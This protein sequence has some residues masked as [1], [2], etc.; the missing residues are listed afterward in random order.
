MENFYIGNN[1]YIDEN[2]DHAIVKYT[3]A[4]AHLGKFAKVYAH[5]AACYL[6]L[7]DYMNALEDCNKA[8]AL[9]ASEERCYLRKGSA[10]FFLEDYESAKETFEAGKKICE[11]MKTGKR[12]TGFVAEYTRFIR[13]CDSE[14]AEEAKEA[15]VIQAQKNKEKEIAAA[16]AAEKSKS[17]KNVALPLGGVKYQYYQSNAKLTIDVLIKGMKEEDVAVDITEDSIKVVLTAA[18]TTN[19]ETVI[20]KPLYDTVVVDKCKVTVKKTKVE[21][22]LVKEQ[23]R[24]W[25]SLEGAAKEKKPSTVVTKPKETTTNKD[26][27]PLPRAYA[28][29]KDWDRVEQA[30]TEELDAEKPEGEEA[31]QKLFRD[32]YAKASPET[33][34]AMNKS[35]QT[36]GGTVLSTNWSE[37][38]KTDYEK[39]RQAPKGVEWKNWEGEKLPM[40]EL[41]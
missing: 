35:F 26:G 18:G 1:Y 21:I 33:Q 28:S 38:E 5:R 34:R 14:L 9:D 25:P 3:E 37:V 40:K 30:I 10:L 11:E 29:H 2:Y 24:D 8:I 6:K 4:I 39:N 7:K 23:P 27:K 19:T 41:D 15:A 22:V 17:M 32:I 36:S 12:K 20:D 13:K 31:L 16:A